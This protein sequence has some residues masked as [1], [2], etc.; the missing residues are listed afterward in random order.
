MDAAVS[1]KQF[2]FDNGD[3]NV[4]VKWQKQINFEVNFFSDCA[5]KLFSKESKDGA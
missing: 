3:V 1:V 5:Q 2:Q 4:N